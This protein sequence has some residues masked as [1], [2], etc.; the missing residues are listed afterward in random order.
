MLTPMKRNRLA[1]FT[2]IEM[3]IVVL[4]IS[5]LV[6]IALPNWKKARESA[7]TQT[8]IS[9]LTR[10][11]HAKEQFAMEGRRAD[12][13]AVAWVNLVP[14]YIKHQPSCPGDGDYTIEPVGQTPKC[15]IAGHEVQ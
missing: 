13:S 3:M 4:V 14:A 6:A 15:S 5:T 11:A 12:G 8:C 9:N 10:V 1:G 2:L 7:R